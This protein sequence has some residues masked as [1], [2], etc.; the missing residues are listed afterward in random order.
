MFVVAVGP[1]FGAIAGPLGAQI[2][3]GPE[4]EANTFTTGRQSSPRVAS[5][6]GGGFLVSW[7]DVFGGEDRLQVRRFDAAGAP[8]GPEFQ[9]NEGGAAY[10]ERRPSSILV[11][12]D[13][14]FTVIWGSV[15]D[16]P[17]CAFCV[18]GSA[19][20]L[21][22]AG[23]PLG[24]EFEI[25]PEAKYG[26]VPVG[27]GRPDGNFV[28][29]TNN[30]APIELVRYDASGALQGVFEIH[31]ATSHD[32]ASPNLAAAPTG[33]FVVVWNDW[34]RQGYQI[35]ADNIRFQPFAAT[36]VPAGAPVVLT[37]PGTDGYRYRPRAARNGAGDYLVV[38]EEDLGPLGVSG[39]FVHYIQA[40]V[41]G[42]E[43]D[44]LGPKFQVNDTTSGRQWA[45]QVAAGPDGSF[46]VTWSDYPVGE[47]GGDGSSSG[48]RAR[49]L[50]ADGSPTG[51]T[52]VVN[53]Y[54]TGGQRAPSV[55]FLPDGDFV[56]AWTSEGSFG[57]DDSLES[58][59]IRR[60]RL[61]M[62]ADGF[63]TGDTSR[64]SAGGR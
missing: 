6:P 33:E 49:H 17:G 34:E 18:S 37:A 26:F 25:V 53:S 8:L 50:S 43:G 10:G 54:T 4:I 57:H 27:A 38:W 20:R 36:G 21:A 62:F 31:A 44:A 42:F 56:V 24:S 55:A 11:D 30:S 41:Y 28:V 2:P 15:G 40:R 61:P 39:S 19:R 7:G 14:E 3:L 13:G 1:F 22:A 51:P 23:T 12:E 47:R 59:Q 63:E 52:F 46:V 9:V 58:I 32:H 60:F 35:V 45:T 64:W 5:T 48:V 29:A 16:G